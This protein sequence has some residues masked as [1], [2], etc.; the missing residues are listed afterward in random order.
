MQ[1]KTF[2][3]HRSLFDQTTVGSAL[4]PC[5]L[6]FQLPSSQ[7]IQM[8]SIYGSVTNIGH[9]SLNVMSKRFA[10]K[11]FL[12]SDKILKEGKNILKLNIFT[13]EMKSMFKQQ[14]L[15]T[16]HLVFP[17]ALRHH[18]HRN[19]SHHCHLSHEHHQSCHYQTHYHDQI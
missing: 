15:L 17:S 16:A 4:A 11:F 1:H 18:H 6:Y 12:K 9:I 5:N 3:R 14:L 19:L 13:V 7:C 10:P 2:L 8:D